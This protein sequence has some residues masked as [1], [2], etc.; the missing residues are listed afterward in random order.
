LLERLKMNI[1]IVMH[2][3]MFAQHALKGIVKT[4]SDASNDN[5]LE[6]HDW[7]NYLKP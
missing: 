3:T 6:A 1:E 5:D 2:C 4:R 7:H